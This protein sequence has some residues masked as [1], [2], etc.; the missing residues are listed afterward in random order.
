M[1]CITLGVMR[2]IRVPRKAMLMLT[3]VKTHEKHHMRIHETVES[4]LGMSRWQICI[5]ITY[6]HNTSNCKARNFL[7]I[8]KIHILYI[9]VDVMLCDFC[10]QGLTILRVDAPSLLI[11]T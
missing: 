11:R 1:K 8:V 7:G 5:C 10:I 2:N 6:T 9:N 3:R 4:I